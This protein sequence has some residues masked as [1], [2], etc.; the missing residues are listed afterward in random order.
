MS[1]DTD[2]YLYFSVGLLKGS[3]ALEALRQDA[4]KY[5]MIDH[6][7]QLIALRLTEYYE[8]MTRGLLPPVASVSIAAP[9]AGEDS[10]LRRGMV[11]PGASGTGG[12]ASRVPAGEE[13]MLD[14][15]GTL[16]ASPDV[17]RNAEEAADYWAI[18]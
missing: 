5:H 7:G 13:E 11:A 15:E 16:T 6:P 9:A 1:Q 17:D 2:K 10:S 8:I 14:D 4:L 12:G 18:M 3:P